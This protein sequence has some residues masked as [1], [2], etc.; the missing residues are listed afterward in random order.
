VLRRGR[1]IDLPFPRSRVLAAALPALA[2]LANA[3]PAIRLPYLGD[4]Y[5]LLEQYGSS[6][7]TIFH[8]W[9][10]IAG[11]KWLRPMGWSLWWLYDRLSPL[12][13]TLAHAVN[14]ALLVACAILAVPAMRRCGVPRGIAVAAATIFAAHPIALELVAW[15]T[16]AYSLLSAGFALAAIASIPVGRLR[17]RSL[18]RPA[19]FA[20]AAYLSK[21]DSYCLPVLAGAAAARFRLRGVRRA[22]HVGIAVAV[23]LALVVVGRVVLLEK[24]GAYR[25]PMTGRSLLVE[26]AIRGPLEAVETELPVEY[27]LLERRPIGVERRRTWAETARVLLPALLLALGGASA[28]ARRG[29]PRGAAIFA[30]FLAPTSSVLPV[31]PELGL[32]RQLFSPSIGLAVVCAS[33]TAGMPLGRRGRWVAVSAFAGLALAVGRGNVAAWR[34]AGA[35]MREAVAL[36][37]PVVAR[38]PKDAR[39]L[40]YGIPDSVQG[41]ISGR[42]GA[43]AMRRASGRTDVTVFA[44]VH[45]YDDLDVLIDVRDGR[46]TDEDPKLAVTLARGES[47]RFSDRSQ[48]RVQDARESV[49]A[50]GSLRLEGYSENASVRFP[51]IGVPPNAEVAIDVDGDATWSTGPQPVPIVATLRIGARY[52]RLMLTERGGRI[53]DSAKWLRLETIPVPATTLRL[54]SISIR[55]Y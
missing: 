16:N 32:V 46:A 40:V 1:P 18:V 19:L 12:D 42:N 6:K 48:W 33:L 41:A 22:V 17:V 51:A 43:P 10:P 55:V 39:I 38:A 7:P 53:P 45:G 54:R 11:D 20:L 9:M 30:C 21:E 47:V 44:P 24:G 34:A 14:A 49:D 31:G 52:H 15:A 5:L 3:L 50:D 26:R 35:E 2:A 27:V 13:G 25:D 8:A 37:T 29:V 4:D 28:A 23:P 36:A